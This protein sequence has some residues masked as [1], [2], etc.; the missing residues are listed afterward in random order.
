MK[1]FSV[2]K[3]CIGYNNLFISVLCSS[4]SNPEAGS[5]E[6]TYNGINT[7][8]TFLC[9][10]GYQIHGASPSVLTCDNTGAWD[11]SEPNCGNN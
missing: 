4:L 7:V 5:H 11:S 6:L 10:P 3:S 8:A 2:E 9:D 1:H